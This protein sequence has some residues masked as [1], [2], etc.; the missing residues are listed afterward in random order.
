M[1]Y[2]RNTRTKHG[3]LFSFNNEQ[4]NAHAEVHLCSHSLPV[5]NP[6]YTNAKAEVWEL[7]TTL[8]RLVAEG[9]TEECG[10]TCTVRPTHA[11][12]RAAG[13]RVALVATGLVLL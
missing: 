3:I 6:A 11:E 7:E 4:Q 10:E 1:N 2:C 12:A 5:K 8:V 9:G 13:A